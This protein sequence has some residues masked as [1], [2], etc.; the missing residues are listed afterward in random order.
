LRLPPG[1]SP[2]KPNQGARRKCHTAPRSRR[3]LPCNH[4]T[5]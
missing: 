2:I 4:V 5:M 1:S 3:P